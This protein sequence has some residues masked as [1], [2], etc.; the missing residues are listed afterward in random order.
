MTGTLR[1]DLRQLGASDRPIIVGPWLSEVGFELLYWIPFLR[2]AIAVGK[3]RPEQLWILSR[4]GCRS[5]YADLTP[6]YL[7]LYDAYS[8]ADLVRKNH[9]R[10]IEQAAHGWRVGLRRGQHTAKQYHLSSVEREMVTSAAR[11]VGLSDPL[12]LHPSLM[13]RAFRPLWKRRSHEIYGQWSQMT[14]SARLM[15]PAL[16]RS[17]PEHYVAVKFYASEALPDQPARQVH[18]RQMVKAITDV[19]DV[20]LL[21]TGTKYDEHGEFAIADHPR[22]HRVRFDPTTNLDQQTAIIAGSHGFVG[23]Y[24]GFAYLAPFLGIPTVGLYGMRNFRNDHLRLMM[25]VAHRALGVKFQAT[26]L[27]DGL[28]LIRRERRTW[29]AHAA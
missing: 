18:V 6:N 20:V 12:V 15:A 25:D 29:V 14:R 23:T 1:E 27:L 10:T 22:V 7:E 21:H 5:W 13:Y 28:S 24:G 17:L 11:K 4:G 8:P 9:E 19:S 16:T 26:D 3:I 2:W